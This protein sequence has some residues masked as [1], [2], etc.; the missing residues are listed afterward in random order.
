MDK[1]DYKFEQDPGFIEELE[2]H[3]EIT[4]KKEI[5]SLA[6][7]GSRVG[8]YLLTRNNL[9]AVYHEALNPLTREEV[10]IEMLAEL[11]ICPI[12][13]I[14]ERAFNLLKKFSPQPYPINSVRKM[15]MTG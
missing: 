14:R 12:L 1:I 13:D 7:T 4:S 2:N 11:L 8:L 15:L 6:K 9:E 3:S 5:V 10:A